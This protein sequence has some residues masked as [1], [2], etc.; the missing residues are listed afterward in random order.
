M[1]QNVPLR[2]ALLDDKVVVINAD[3]TMPVAPRVVA[4]RSPTDLVCIMIAQANEMAD[5]YQAR[6]GV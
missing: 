1:N 2:F 6:F 3:G 4:T 5:R